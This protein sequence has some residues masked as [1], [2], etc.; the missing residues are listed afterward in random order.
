MVF[1]A[2]CGRCGD[3]EKEAK[4]DAEKDVG[5]PDTGETPNTPPETRIHKL[6]DTTGHLISALYGNMLLSFGALVWVD[7]LLGNGLTPPDSPERFEII[8]AALTGALTLLHLFC[9]ADK[10]RK[11]RGF[12]ESLRDAWCFTAIFIVALMVPV[13]LGI[14]VRWLAMGVMSLIVDS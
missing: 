14:G 5:Y 6:A 8:A 4:S 7:F 11:N 12:R 10:R 9:A 1:A 3:I 2:E 13:T